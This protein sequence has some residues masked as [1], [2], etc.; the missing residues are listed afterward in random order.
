MPLFNVEI[1]PERQEE[2]TKLVE[3][4]GDAAIKKFS[5]VPGLQ[6]PLVDVE[7]TIKLSTWGAQLETL[8][9]A[10]YTPYDESSNVITPHLSIKLSI[11]LPPT[12]SPAQAKKIVIEKL[13]KNIPHN[14]QVCLEGVRSSSTRKLS[15]RNL[16]SARRPFRKI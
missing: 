13:T 16:D 1:P 14:A 7:P 5:T 10:G 6:Y 2:I 11:R 8:T 9:I 12:F 15:G 4:F 3:T